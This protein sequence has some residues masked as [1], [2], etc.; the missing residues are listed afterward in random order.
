[1]HDAEDLAQVYLDQ[2]SC[3]GW[4]WN[5]NGTFVAVFNDPRAVLEAA[6]GELL[7]R[8]L[9]EVLDA[10]VAARWEGRLARALEGESFTVRERVGAATWSISIFPIRSDGEIRFAGC[11]TREAAPWSNTE[12]E[13]RRA[14]VDALKGQEQERDRMSRFLHD[15]IG[16][17]MTAL[18]LQLD[19][20]S[21]DLEAVAPEARDRIG[22]IQEALE[23]MMAEVRAYTYT[24]SPSLVERAGLRSALERIAARVH[25]K[26]S[27]VVQMH[28]DGAARPEPAAAAAVYR[29]AEE[30]V[31]NAI[32]HANCSMIDIAVRCSRTGITLEVRDN[33]TGFDPGDP[34]KVSRGLGLPRMEHYAA[35]AGMALTIES[36]VGGGT[37]I[38]AEARAGA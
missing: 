19:L 6:S 15:S 34:V 24:L 7:G 30:A 2:C 35:E 32:K 37:M 33:G 11:Q 21:M 25:P 8:R 3:R 9:S 4:I 22:K 23:P 28:V 5:R 12:Q 14:V 18:G 16:Q 17:N 13:L 1:M 10:A 20:L 38:R 36:R 31:D 29:I 27:G 26:F